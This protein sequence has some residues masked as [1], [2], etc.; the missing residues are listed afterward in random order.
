RR[1]GRSGNGPRRTSRPP[2]GTSRRAS[3]P[4]RI[5]TPRSSRSRS[6][7]R[8]LPRSP[9][10][11]R[12]FASSARTDLGGTSGRTWSSRTRRWR[13]RPPTRPPCERR[14]SR[15]R[16]VS[17]RAREI[18]V[19]GPRSR[20]RSAPR[21]LLLEILARQD[22]VGD[23]RLEL[24]PLVAPFDE[25]ELGLTDPVDQVDLERVGDAEVEHA[26]MNG[27]DHVLAGEAVFDEEAVEGVAGLDEVP[28]EG[29]LEE[30]LHEL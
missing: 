20:R 19:D 4:R 27:A 10:S 24:D 7:R 28:A 30:V 22:E 15:S 18:E 25:A 26:S 23:Q 12:S 8:A 29:D 21:S 13:P 16:E 17:P 3:K 2:S 6:S 9:S 11:R 5:S 1:A 14:S